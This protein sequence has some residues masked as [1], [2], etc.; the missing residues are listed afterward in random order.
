LLDQAQSKPH[1][2][3]KDIAMAG[4]DYDAELV[5]LDEAQRAIDEKRKALMQR[6]NEELVDVF[7]KVK[8]KDVPAAKLKKVLVQIK[9]I[10]LDAAAEKLGVTVEA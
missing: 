2:S 8:F 6:R 3:K 4:N 7:R 10:G 5:K 9:S 1:R